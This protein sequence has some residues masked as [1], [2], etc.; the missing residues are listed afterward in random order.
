M[1]ETG[2]HTPGAHSTLGA[3]IGRLGYF[4]L[5]FGAIVGSGWVV[6]LGDWLKAAGP[7]GVVLGLASGGAAMVCVSLCYG[8]LAGR[9]A[10]AGGEFLYVIRSLGRFPGFLV[11]WFLTLFAVSIC[12]FESVVLTW[13]V[14]V[15]MPAIDLPPLYSVGNS[16]ITLDSLL[17]GLAGAAV[18]GIL[19]YRGSASAIRFQNLVTVSFIV[20]MAVLIICGFAFGSV[21]NLTPLFAAQP[22][23]SLGSGL[24]WVFSTSAFFLNGWQTAL[25][26][27]EERRPGMT[28]K[29]A[30]WHM[31]LGIFAA[32]LFYGA[33]VLAASAARPW[34]SLVSLDLPAVSAF[35]AL[36]ANG[37]LGTAIVIAALISL[38]KTWSA[39]AWVGSR[40]LV[41]QSREGML[42]S[43]LAI[44]EP[45]S[46]SPQTAVLVVTALTLTGPLLGRSALLPIVNMVSICLALSI[47]LCLIV[48]LRQRRL[49]HEEPSFRVPG[50]LI[51]IWLALTAACV[52]IAV[53]I[54]KPLLDGDGSIPTEWILLTGWAVLGSAAWLLRGRYARHDPEAVPDGQG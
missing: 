32:A 15:L 47:I 5:A 30:V 16:N 9:F 26:A 29:S 18:I 13:L 6:V 37:A 31:S 27:I 38:L 4:T 20:M 52:M 1:I 54:V 35:G 14:R 21:H 43:S 39:L 23:R 50:G 19:H 45:R 51:T 41:A 11:G 2:A 46:G 36:F 10:C 25:H 42:P 8:E 24:L 12:A 40:L 49:G 53:A 48:L 22:P 7:G 3:A 33:V 17:I 28:V 34:R 44:C